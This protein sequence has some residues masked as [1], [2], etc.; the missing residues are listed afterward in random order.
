MS[1]GERDEVRHV[2]E[3]RRVQVL[4]GVARQ[5]QVSKV[6]R[7]LRQGRRWHGHELISGLWSNLITNF[8]DEKLDRF[9]TKMQYLKKRSSFLKHIQ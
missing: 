3:H 6:R 1:E 8:Y 4:D 2:G 9:I 5:V 7:H